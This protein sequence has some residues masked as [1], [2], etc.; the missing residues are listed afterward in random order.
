MK[1]K[2]ERWMKSIVVSLVLIISFFSFG[3]MADGET[4]LSIVLDQSMVSGSETF[5]VGVYCVPAQPIKSYEFSIGFNTTL[6]HANE[7]SVGNIFDGYSLFTNNGT[8][9]NDIGEIDLIYGLIIGAGNVTDPGYFINISFTAQGVTGT[10]EIILIGPGVTNETAYVPLSYSNGSVSI[11]ASAP[12]ITD[13][14]SS[15][16]Y[17]GDSFVFNV[18]VS[19]DVDDAENLSIY[20]DWTHGSNHANDSM[21]Y[22]GG[23]YFE[24]IVTL[25]QNSVDDLSYSFYSWDSI[26][27]TV[28][29]MAS[30]VSIHDNDD[31][32]ISGLSAA[33]S[34]QMQDGWVNLSAMI[35]DNINIDM[36]SVNISCP[37]GTYLNISL[38]SFTGDTYYYNRTFQAIGSYEYSF[39]AKDSSGNTVSSGTSLFIILDGT[40]PQI[41]DLGVIESNPVDTESGFGWINISCLVID[42][43]LDHVQ[44][45]RT[46]PDSSVTNTSMDLSIGGRYY[47]NTSF[48]EYGNYSYY[49]WADDTN[50]N[51]NISTVYLFSMPPNWDINIDGNITVFDFILI[52]NHFN[53]TGSL[54]WIREDVD[55]NGEIKV[56]DIVLAAN[57]YGNYWW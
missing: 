41:N 7:V 3:V 8:I 37:N 21:V 17:T 56:L 43:E 5:T 57:Q 52:S 18:S 44:L 29:T 24:K 15:V 19:D 2:Y 49:I 31:P 20:V 36:I 4:T 38:T 40:G 50:N 22:M 14:S 27:N 25:D 46:N 9:D 34:S 11:D 47:V 16:G 39:F 48:S 23:S 45:L 42:D 13:Q 55:N 53:E 1:K 6:L 35:T 28:V 12:V 32:S 30:S 33:P 26:G 51:Q 54:G 10:S